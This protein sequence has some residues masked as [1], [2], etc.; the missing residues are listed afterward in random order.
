MHLSERRG[1]YI[2]FDLITTI[3]GEPH[4]TLILGSCE[5]VVG[6]DVFHRPAPTCSSRPVRRFC[7][8]T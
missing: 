2:L 5:A 7:E 3:T 8:L 4:A 6:A 1:I